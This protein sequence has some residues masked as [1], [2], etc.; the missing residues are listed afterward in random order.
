V[1]AHD[2]P[3]ADALTRVDRA[4]HQRHALPQAREPVASA[5]V[6]GLRAAV[7]RDLEL[8]RVLLPP[9]GDPGASRACVAERVRQRLLDDPIRGEVDARRQL[10]RLA[11]DL[12]LHRKASLANGP[13]EHVDGAHRGLRRELGHR[14]L[15]AEQAD[16]PAHL[17]ER[18]AP[19]RL[20]H[21]ERLPFSLLIGTQEAAHRT[22]LNG[23]DGDGVRHDV[24]QLARDPAAL[25][26]DRAVGGRDRILRALHP[27]D[28]SV[29][30][31]EVQRIEDGLWR[32]TAPH[33]DWKP[34]D[35]WD[36]DVGCVYWEADDG[37]V[38]VDPLVPSDDADRARFLEALDRDVERVDLPVAIL[39]TCEWH[40]RSSAELAERYDGTVVGPT[41][42]TVLPGAAAAI[43]APVAEE[44]VY[45][46]PA[47]RS[48]VPGDALISSEKGVTLCPASWL[49][50]RGGLAQLR[51]DLAPLLELPIER[52]LTS[53]GP[54]MLADGRAAL[55]QAL[56]AA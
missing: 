54:P 55:A 26:G 42:A 48:I 22:R 3:T 18:L 49:S 32:W 11:F 25:L 8:E 38:L 44:V 16:E 17:G 47:A 29:R 35:D 4:S 7:V 40:G 50:G 23:H 19:R 46:L 31:V 15:L 52:V 39:L 30:G 53:H 27:R 56:G 10:P 41:V 1:G 2:E 21:L 13:D 33:P 14:A 5:A 20:D 24:V 12:E 6:A 36:A 37:V 34:R 9:D 43:A 51:R 28:A 45:W